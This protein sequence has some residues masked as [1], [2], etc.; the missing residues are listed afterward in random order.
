MSFLYISRS[1]YI[2]IYQVYILQKKKVDKHI[3]SYAL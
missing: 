3:I 2:A 1:Y